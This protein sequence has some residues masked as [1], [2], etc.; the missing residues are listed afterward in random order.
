[1]VKFGERI[2]HEA[3]ALPQPW[4]DLILDYETLKKRLKAAVEAAKSKQGS[5]SMK[6]FVQKS[7]RNS[8][9][10]LLDSEIEKVL[11]HYRKR[12]SMLT[13]T[14]GELQ[15][16]TDSM[17]GAMD[18]TD[19]LSVDIAGLKKL[20]DMWVSAA[21]ELSQLLLYLSLNTEGIRKIMKKYAKSSGLPAVTTGP[22]LTT[23]EFQ[24]ESLLGGRI[25]QGSFLPA[26]TVQEIDRMKCHPELVKASKNIKKGFRK[27]NEMKRRLQETRL[28]HK[29]S[30]QRNLTKSM[31]DLKYSI[32]SFSDLSPL[33]VRLEEAERR[34]QSN[35]N[36]IRATPQLVESYV[37]IFT[38]AVPEHKAYATSA[39]LVM[40][41]VSAFLYMVNYNLVLPTNEDFCHHLGSSASM[42]GAIVGFADLTAIAI[43]LL[44]SWWSC[45]SFKQPLMA[46]SML[47]L[48]GNVMYCLAWDASGTTQG[49]CL[50]LAGR[51]V[52][53]MGSARAVNRRYIADFVSKKSR[54]TASSAFVAA[55]TLGA[56]MGPLLAVPLSNL[57]E[58]EVGGF[59]INPITAGGWAMALCWLIYTTAVMLCFRDPPME[60]GEG[61]TA[62]RHH[63]SCDE[64]H[65]NTDQDMQPVN[66]L[67]KPLLPG[68]SQHIEKSS[69]DMQP[70]Y[71]CLLS[72]F[73]LKFLQQ[74]MLS[75]V[76]VVTDPFYNWKSTLVGLFLAF[77]SLS[78]LP[79]NFLLALLSSFISDRNLL[80][81]AEVLSVVGVLLM[82][83]YSGSA[84]NIVSYILGTVFVF[85]T[86]IVMEAVSM[87]LLSKKIPEGMARGICNAGLLATQSGSFGRLTGNMLITAYGVILGGFSTMLKVVHFDWLLYGTLG[88]FEVLALVYS[89]IMYKHLKTT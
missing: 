3:K 22:G 68:V 36:V 71:V 59:S 88:A 49:L 1:M 4:Q 40:N 55:S 26:D 41:L 19:G 27:L 44:Y 72:L 76:P 20:A 60:M 8:F 29:Y 23:L 79:V 64:E 7:T 15:A 52:T 48:I 56:A 87:S 85:A 61:G 50:L 80:L 81:S 35:L 13:E 51:L 34:A 6:G 65:G 11:A 30:P 25:E 2:L 77:L 46:S 75:S 82:I 10:H 53:G 47:S 21:K 73:A 67:A 84:P 43:S 54:T 5:S 39:G 28:R 9:Q 17:A 89:A 18:D 63:P 70:V 32:E 14:L 38:P 57:A 45:R 31:D 69:V 33:V 83:S 16:E 86:T 42:A 12:S 24:H 74:G 37:G 58:T 62:Q 66:S 78:M